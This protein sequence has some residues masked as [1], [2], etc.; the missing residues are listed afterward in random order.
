MPGLSA[1]TQAAKAAGQLGLHED[2]ESDHEIDAEVLE[3]LGIEEDEEDEPAAEDEE[4][5]VRH[6]KGDPRP[7]MSRGVLSARLAFSN[8]RD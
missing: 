7:A 1:T 4:G 8:C 6:D 2:S 5:E 3:E